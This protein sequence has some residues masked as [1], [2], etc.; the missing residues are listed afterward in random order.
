MICISFFWDGGCSA[1]SLVPSSLIPSGRLVTCGINVQT[2]G[3]FFYQ[4]ALSARQLVPAYSRA[5]EAKH[6]VSRRRGGLPQN[7]QQ[8]PKQVIIITTTFFD[9]TI[10]LPRKTARP[11]GARC[12]AL[13]YVSR[14]AES[15]G[16]EIGKHIRLK[17]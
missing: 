5:R 15:S 10:S 9:N 13:G 14:A 6:L 3:I 17:I 7:M 16:G 2:E 1:D 8:K 11:S 12:S 4:G